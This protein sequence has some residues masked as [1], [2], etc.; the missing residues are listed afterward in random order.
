MFRAFY[1]ALICIGL[2]LMVFGAIGALVQAVFFLAVL[3]AAG[4]VGGFIFLIAKLL[5]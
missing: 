1:I 2:G 3:A 5:T 4:L